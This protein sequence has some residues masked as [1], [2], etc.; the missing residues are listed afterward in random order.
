[1]GIAIIDYILG[2]GRKSPS[3]VEKEYLLTAEEELQ[4]RMLAWNCCVNLK[5]NII[6]RSDFRTYVK[7]AEVRGEEWWLWNV[8]PNPNQS[9]TAFLH[10]L[11]HQLHKENEVLII[12]TKDRK[13]KEHLAVADEFQTGDKYPT[14]QNTY[15]GVRVEDLSYSKTFREDEVLYLRLN[16]KKL[17]PAWEAMMQC[18][19]RVLAAAQKSYRWGRGIHVKAKVSQVAAG[20]EDFQKNFREYMEKNLKPWMES[21]NGALPEFE[22]YE[23]SLVEKA[24]TEDS[25]KDIRE[26]Y[27][28]IFDYTAICLGIAPAIFT[29]NVADSKD[30][31]TR[32]MTTG[33]DPILDQLQ[34][35]INRKRYGFEAYAEGNYLQIDSSSIIHFDMF[36]TGAAVEK[37]IG[38]GVYSVNDVLV[39]AG[40]PKIHEPWADQHWLT[41]NIT[42]I[43]QA[44]KGLPNGKGGEK[45]ER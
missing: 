31:L 24:R 42:E 22:G 13:G 10:K 2:K 43:G 41:L 40:K 37:L 29:G 33:I 15:T 23:Y 26:L 17:N 44:A 32:T 6:G 39:A 9:S 19:E 18:Y 16:A 3:A 30:A 7:N 20:A 35:E 12:E 27:K 34:E 45:G 11:V 14:K 5:A 4:V 38:S 8:E 1:M 25:V 28:E 21:D 36:S